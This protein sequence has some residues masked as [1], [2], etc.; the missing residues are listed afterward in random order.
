MSDFES[1]KPKTD[2]LKINRELYFKKKRGFDRNQAEVPPIVS[3]TCGWLEQHGMLHQQES[4]RVID[5][6]YH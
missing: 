4:C 3:A 1:V 2:S 5:E 6:H